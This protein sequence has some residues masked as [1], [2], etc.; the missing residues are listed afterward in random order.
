M[1]LRLRRREIELEEKK[2]HRNRSRFATVETILWRFAP[3]AHR[4]HVFTPAA[5]WDRVI[6]KKTPSKSESLRDCRNYITTLR[7]CKIVASRL[8]FLGHTVYMFLRLRRRGIEL[9]EKTASK[10]VSKWP[11][12]QR[13][14]FKMTYSVQRCHIFLRFYKY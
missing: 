6:E 5:P 10:S 8:C 11:K 4:I 2:R 3:G 13:K 12:Y 9:E 7:A 1:F 14:S